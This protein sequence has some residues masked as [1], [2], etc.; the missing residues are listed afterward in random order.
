[1]GKK[2][3]IQDLSLKGQKVLM[4][5]DFNV[6]L[7][8]TGAISDDTRIQ[9]AL[10]SIRYVL[11]QGGSVIL[12]SHLGRPKGERK[13]EFSL[14]PCASHLSRLLGKEVKMAPDCVGNE[15]QALA[16]ALKAGEL[17]LLENLRFHLAETKP[18]RDPTFAE[19]LAK[20][21]DLYVN[22]AFGTAHRAH[23]STVTITRCFPGKA[24][25]GFLMSEEI[26]HLGGLLQNPIRPFVAIIGGA[27]I[28]SK[29][30]VL[31]S[32]L[33][34]VDTLVIG[35]GMAFTFLKVAGKE[36]GNSLVEEELLDTAR[37][38][39]AKAEEKKVQFLLPID[40]MVADSF[41]NEA[42]VQ[43]VTT[44]EGIPEG[45]MGLDI[46]PETIKIVEESVRKAGTV[47]WNGPL[48]VFELPNF[49]HG[50]KA[51]AQALALSKAK[52]VVGGGDS[53]AALNQMGLADQM[54]HI[55]TG[56]GASLEY[57]EQGELPG[58]EALS[59]KKALLS[60]N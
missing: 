3:A 41:S 40:S 7:D 16:D 59:E 2:L 53:V 1:M 39:L 42:K 35:G 10:P 20:L 5:V 19:K 30:G 58:I 15:T 17:L 57:I 27:K 21:A 24:A 25:A 11:E 43:K 8:E 29:I 22:D 23:S 47:L 26:E 50:T 60:K 6:P 13:L 52:S 32:L 46:G 51:V 33:E 45:W 18:E 44:D 9:R 48:G 54:T 56:G 34:K 36:I 37:Q 38:V 12:M 14:A 4:R 49:A 28:S 31:S 55:S